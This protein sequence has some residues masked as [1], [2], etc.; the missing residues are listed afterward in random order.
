MTGLSAAKAHIF[1]ITH[2]DNVPWLL[3]NGICCRNSGNRDPS[4]REIGNKE[5]IARRHVHPV[6]IAPHGTL[7]DYVPFYF[8]SHSPMLYNIKTGM[9][10]PQLPMREIVICAT[11]LKYLQSL[12]ITFVFTDSHA[13]LQTTNFYNSLS[14]LS[15]IDWKLLN[16]R[17]FRRDHNDLGK[18]DRYQAEALVRGDV[19]INAIQAIIC[20]SDTE[21]AHVEQFVQ[22]IGANLRV[23]A[24]PGRFFT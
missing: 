20:F 21:K 10:V 17:D 23:I 1:R 7:S 18:F 24:D 11:S 19:P 14:D 5:L 2:I 9:N 8:T 15:N 13:Y 16:A 3:A 22:N 6:P 4:F 12:G